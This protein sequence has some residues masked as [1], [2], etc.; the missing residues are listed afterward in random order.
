MC[1]CND[2][3]HLFHF[4]DLCIIM[5]LGL[6]KITLF[7]YIAVA[8]VLLT[9]GTC[10]WYHELTPAIA[11]LIY[12]IFAIYYRIHHPI[13]TLL[14]FTSLYLFLSYIFIIISFCFH[15]LLADNQALGFIFQSLGSYLI[16]NNI[17][18]KAFKRKYLKLVFLMCVYA[19]PIYLLIEYEIS[20]FPVIEKGFFWSCM[21]V[22]VGWYSGLFHRFAGF[23]HEPG[24]CQIILNLALILYIN[25][26][27]SW[28]LSKSEKLE[29]LV[30]LIGVVLTK[31]TGAYL[32]LLVIALCCFFEKIKSRFFL[33]IFVVMS[34]C[35]Y[36]IWASDVVQNKFYKEDG[37]SV[38]L[39]MRQADNLAMFQM[40]LEE[41]WIGWGLG[42]VDH[43]KRSDALGNISNSNGILYMTSSVGIPWLILFLF[44][45]LMGIYGLGFRNISLLFV[46]LAFLMLESNE[47]FIECPVSYILL[48]LSCKENFKS[49]SL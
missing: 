34:L 26:I 40:T 5:K 23:Y 38:S 14:G 15:P 27:R 4:I 12:L 8:L 31:S 13:G 21:G 6:T 36:S 39:M 47:R 3:E 18:Y 11:C 10:M 28:N 22:T 44:F 7:E 37:D 41:P 43:L 45:L 19:I 24:A 29:L 17:S 2:F 32:T 46:L 33:P 48:F 16:L 35:I 42:S 20:P 9:S 25:D 49:K 1:S 30:I